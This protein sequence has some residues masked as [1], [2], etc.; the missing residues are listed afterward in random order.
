LA[1]AV[2][3]FAA[4]F[5]APGQGQRYEGLAQRA[6]MFG[7]VMQRGIDGNLDILRQLVIYAAPVAGLLV[8]VMVVARGD[9]IARAEQA[10]KD[11][12][13]ERLRFVALA[14]VAGTLIAC[15]IFVSPKLGPRFYYVSL[16]LLLAGFIGVIDAVLTPRQL[17]PLLVLAL[18]ASAY[19]AYRTVPLYTKLKVQSDARI[20][21][22]K[23]APAQKVFIADAWSQ[24]DETWWSLGDDFR[25][26]KKREL[27][28][29]YFDLGGVVFRA[30]NPEIPLGVMGARLVPHY[31]VTPPGCLDEHGGFAL[32]SFKGF[33]LPGLHR[34]MKI[35]VALLRERL[36]RTGGK[37]DKL[38]LEVQLDD[39][40]ARLPRKTLVGRW[41]PDRFE[42]P[43][44]KITRPSRGRMRKIELPAELAAPSTEVFVYNVG[45][46][47]RKL[48]PE[49]TYVPWK[50]GVYW[51]L[52]CTAEEC[53]VIAATRQG[54]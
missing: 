49:R 30:Y 31:T 5:F 21:A 8:L 47:A 42:G 25:D 54:G 50:S 20:A 1:G 39:P 23:A 32:G 27:V 24:V 11:V 18:I 53:W 13:R 41:W 6:G 26:A 2:L 16:A 4:L 36:T 15:T 19:A 29:K 48:G 35:A 38:E 43:V 22:L 40:D 33:D 46:E 3:G 51:I 44:G 28:A 12:V 37:L 52:G 14:V 17:R 45:G 10:T 7:R 34:E 9:M